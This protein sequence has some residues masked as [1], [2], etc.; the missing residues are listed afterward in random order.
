MK[1]PKHTRG[2]PGAGMFMY[3]YKYVCAYLYVHFIYIYTVKNTHT[4][5]FIQ[6]IW[7]KPGDLET[8]EFSEL[9]ER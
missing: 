9:L 3:I 8:L 5:I 2:K 4:Y 6:Y 1:M 7:D